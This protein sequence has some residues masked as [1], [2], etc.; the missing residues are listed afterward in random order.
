MY[1]NL[2]LYSYQIQ[3]LLAGVSAAFFVVSTAL[4]QNVAK[5]TP[6]DSIF[7]NILN[8]LKSKM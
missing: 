4:A 6:K 3:H 1:E 5:S 7:L 8:L 2:Q